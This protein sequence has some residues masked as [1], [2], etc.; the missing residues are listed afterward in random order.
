MFLFV[1]FDRKKPASASATPTEVTSPLPGGAA[2]TSLPVTPASVINSPNISASASSE[3]I[4]RY[5]CLMILK[6]LFK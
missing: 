1:K 5:F 4:L 2:S 6:S 3:F